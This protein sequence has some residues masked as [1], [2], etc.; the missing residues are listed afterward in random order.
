MSS[1]PCSRRLARGRPWAAQRLGLL[2]WPCRLAAQGLLLAATALPAWVSAACVDEERF[3][4]PVSAPVSAPAAPAAPAMAAST[5]LPPEPRAQLLNL[6]RDALVRSNGLGAAKLLAEAS[7]QDIEEARAARKPQ[8]SLLGSVAPSLTSANTLTGAQLQVNAG[9]SI[10]QTLYDGGRGDRMVGWRFQQSEAA[11]LGLLSIQEQITL[12]TASLAFERSRFRMQAMIYGQNVRKMTCLVQALEAIVNADKGR[13]S[14]LVQA[15]KQMGMADLQQAQAVSQ[16]RQVEAKLRRMAGD[17]LPA[18]AGFGTLL[19][20]VPELVDLLS[21][22]ERSADIGAMDA[23]A[24]GLREIARVVEASTKPQVSWNLGGSVTVA[25]GTAALAGDS[26]SS[27]NLSLSGGVTVNIPLLNPSVGYSIQAARKRAEAATFQRA[28]A[29]EARRQRIVETHEQAGAAFERVRRVA[30]VLRDSEQLRNF[31]LQQWQQMGRR[32]L[33]D[34]IGAESE[35]Y[36]LRVQYINALH[37]GQQMN[38]T[39]TSLGTGLSAWLQ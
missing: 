2:G 25:G 37:D 14:E 8:A 28:E 20:A 33:F 18:V 29:L 34:V 10:S 17:G 19:L 23:N 13:L 4:T 7:A 22:A 30:L 38:A 5:P 31:T 32:S 12:S 26:G 16:A 3:E 39:L 35:H 9:V 21:A 36:N 15:R 1:K 27:H 24:A 6:V 11:R